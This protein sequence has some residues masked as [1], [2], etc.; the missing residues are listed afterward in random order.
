MEPWESAGPDEAIRRDASGQT[1]A[2]TGADGAQAVAVTARRWHYFEL[3]PCSATCLGLV[4][5]ATHCA[6]LAAS[7]QNWA[8]PECG[9]Y[10]ERNRAALESSPSASRAN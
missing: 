2:P 9:Y 7:T 10:R 1:S 5:V 8:W 6:Q 4:S 3:F